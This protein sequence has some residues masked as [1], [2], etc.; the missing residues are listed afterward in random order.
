MSANEVIWHPIRYRYA[1]MIVF[2]DVD[3]CVRKTSRFNAFTLKEE[4]K[5]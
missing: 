3:M 4:R 2:D 1:K 5:I